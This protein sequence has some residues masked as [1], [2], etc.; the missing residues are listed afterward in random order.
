MN[1]PNWTKYRSW[2]ALLLAL[3][4]F[5]LLLLLRAT[6]MLE[7][8][9][10]HAYD[11][12]N[13]WMAEPGPSARTV[14]IGFSESDFKYVGTYPYP[15]NVLAGV[16]ER[17]VAAKPRAIYLNVL[18]DIPV[19]PGHARLLDI[20]RRAP[21]L[22]GLDTAAPGE[23]AE[24]MAPPV[25]LE[26]GR[27]GF[28][29]SLDDIDG[30][31][32]S[33]LL[34]DIRGTPM[35]ESS[36][37]KTARHA[38]ASQGVRLDIDAE[39][40]LHTGAQSFRALP[41]T[42]LYAEELL[43]PTWRAFQI[44]YRYLQA[45][46]Q[47]SFQDVLEG[48]VDPA[49]FRDR[50]VVIGTTATSMA[51]MSNTP[52]VPLK[53]SGVASP[54][55]VAHELDNIYSIALDGW[56]VLNLPP[57]AIS[58]LGLLALAWLSCW[59]FLAIRSLGGWAWRAAFW[60]VALVGGAYLAYRLGWWLPVVPALITVALAVILVVNNLIRAE[61]SQRQLIGNFETLFD[62]I[63]D[64]IYALDERDRFRLVNRAFSQLALKRPADLVNL[65][66][67]DLLGQLEV[68]QVSN[69]VHVC[70]ERKLKVF[71]SVQNLSLTE[72]TV[73]DTDGRQL[74]IGI[75][76]S[77]QPVASADTA[78]I[79]STLADAT[80][81]FAVAAHWAEHQGTDLAL[82]LIEPASPDLLQSAFGANYL[83]TLT[84]AM[85][86][87]LERAFPDSV[88][89]LQAD[90]GQLVLL[91]ERR[92]DSV[93][94]AQSLVGQAFSWPLQTDLGDIDLDVRMGCACYGVDGRDLTSL[95]EIART[96]RRELPM[97]T[98]AS[99]LVMS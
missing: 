29:K 94:Q 96:R 97:N 65:P 12:F 14:V 23:V 17:V 28:A 33:A 59:H 39:G 78:Q 61:A 92:I 62:Q 80:Q 18:R 25:L 69:G 15:D 87:R 74:R 46:P 7:A 45:P 24:A 98:S 52:L 89:Q 67:D 40:T 54:V 36:I 26:A 6:H 58:L 90:P 8:T 66:A 32:R 22:Y 41:L 64:P 63:P 35:H 20:Y 9:E 13:R 55:W 31:T 19:E 86:E 68:K 5:G 75:V 38:L 27:Y 77:V 71:G 76:R 91:I 11:V 99:A 3:P 84:A 1:L 73:Q 82:L 53:Y 48:K 93:R 42:T 60:A 37:L 34:A 56:P 44:P 70:G 57:R 4:V 81:R 10:L 83:A 95:L 16:L 43:E 88:F 72:S 51:K 2:R 49:T 47:V 85:A 50:S 21:M 79:T 30:V